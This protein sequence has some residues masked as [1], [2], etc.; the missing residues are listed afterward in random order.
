MRSLVAPVIARSAR[1]D[2]SQL[3]SAKHSEVRVLLSGREGHALTLR[4]LL[5]LSNYGMN[6]KPEEIEQLKQELE[7]KI[8]EILKQNP[9]SRQLKEALGVNDTSTDEDNPGPRTLDE[10]LTELAPLSEDE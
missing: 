4:H 3:S 6:T 2:I 9:Y 8:R 1:S 7:A 10:F 5:P